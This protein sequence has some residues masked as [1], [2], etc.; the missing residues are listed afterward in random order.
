MEAGDGP[1][2]DF[3]KNEMQ[4]SQTAV[5]WR[6][7]TFLG[8]CEALGQDFGFNPNWLRVAFALGLLPS[9]AITLSLY[10]GL[11]ILVAVSRFAFP[12]RQR[13]AAEAVRAAPAA[14]N[15]VVPVDLA[16]AA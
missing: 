5:F 10:L 7:D 15:D 12:A 13:A 1:V 8:V 14:D 11:G 16:V 3:G 2:R 6:H 4:N 9:P